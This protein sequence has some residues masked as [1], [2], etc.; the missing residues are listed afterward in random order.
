MSDK[1]AQTSVEQRENLLPQIPRLEHG[2]L[3]SAAMVCTVNHLATAAGIQLLSN[4]GNAADAA[5]AAS[6]ALTVTN[7]HMCGMG[8]DLWAVVHDGSGS[9]MALNAA[10]RAGSG[11][12]AESMRSEGHSTM[13]FRGDIRSVPIPGCV[14]GWLSLHK[15]YGQAP[16]AQVLA[17]A[18]ELAEQ[19]FPAAKPLSSAAK[20]L[21]EVEGAQDFVTNGRPIS[22]GQKVTRPGIV[23]SLRSIV[24]Q[25]RA[26]W[27]EGEF[28]QGLRRIGNGL[29]SEEDLRV[30][31]AEW[32][33]ALGV[34][35]WGHNIWTTLPSSQGYLS[36]AG[37]VIADGLDGMPTDVHDPLWAHCLIEAAKQAGFDR[38]QSLFDGADGAYLV[39]EQRLGPRRDEIALDRAAALS[40]PGIAGGTIYLCA[41]DANRMGV[42]LIQSNAAG[43]GSHLAVPE[44]GVMLQN[45]GIGF[46]LQ[47]G[48]PAELAPGIRPPSTLSPAL[49]TTEEGAL[50][51]VLGT[52]G[53]DGQPQVV[54]QMLAHLLQA[55]SSPG[56]A[57]TMPRFTLTVPDAVGF[58]TWDKADR[59]SVAVEQGSPWVAG[60]SERGHD[61]EVKPWGT[62]L[63]GHAHLIDVVDDYL[64]G[65]AEPRTGT[66]AA[67]GL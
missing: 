13:P 53:G 64:S 61:V 14:D 40:V 44:V 36:L 49:V 62:G 16:L 41:V 63:F 17:P 46:S 5:I 30:E 45:R 58:D 28:G 54:L 4:G 65:V 57:V 23:R 8:G 43:F 60:L 37:A 48:H 12:D 66:S 47:P 20:L 26:G 59:I 19:G 35:A 39:S 3:G 29:Y 42:S 7:Q 10:G 34:K 52:M 67:V 51:S 9:P 22:F 2:R 25:G 15:A 32:T 18:I 38:S 55:E 24:E 21:V 50:R 27:Y 56:T 6:A 31:Q 11:A 1:V 33:A